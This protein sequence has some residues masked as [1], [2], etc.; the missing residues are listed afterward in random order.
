M[1]ACFYGICWDWLAGWLC[2]CVCTALRVDHIQPAAP[3]F[4]GK[5]YVWPAAKQTHPES[6]SSSSSSFW[7]S[8][9]LL[10]PLLLSMPTCFSSVLSTLWHVLGALLALA[11]LYHAIFASLICIVF[12]LLSD[13]S[14]IIKGDHCSSSGKHQSAVSD[15]LHTNSLCVCVCVCVWFADI[16]SSR[17]TASSV[18]AATGTWKSV[19]FYSSG[20]LFNSI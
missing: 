13:T 18:R 16:H 20:N 19:Y 1:A 15:L 2:V 10:P 11:A 7:P 14:C 6:S 9:R 4:S 12:L 3:M 8:S 5:C 17:L